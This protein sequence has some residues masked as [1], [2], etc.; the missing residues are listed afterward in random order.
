MLGFVGDGQRPGASGQAGV[1]AA[2]EA[3]GDVVEGAVGAVEGED[4]QSWREP[5]GLAAPGG[6]EGGRADH[7]GR[8]RGV[9]LVVEGE[10]EGGEG[11]TEAHVVGEDGSESEAG[12]V[13]EPGE[14]P[15]L[16]AAERRA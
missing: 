8:A 16:V 1:V 15:L 5:L 9:L 10:G 3:V 14:G 12:G 7:Q 13:G 6:D 2:Q 11:F 4:V